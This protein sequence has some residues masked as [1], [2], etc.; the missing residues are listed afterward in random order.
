MLDIAYSFGFETSTF[1]FFCWCKASIIEV[2]QIGDKPKYQWEYIVCVGFV[3]LNTTLKAL[4]SD[5]CN[6]L[7]NINQKK[8]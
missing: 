5:Y 8:S 4:Y 1:F 7:E 6:D 2:M 3:F